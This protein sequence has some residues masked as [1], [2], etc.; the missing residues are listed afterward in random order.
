M[1][2]TGTKVMGWVAVAV[3]AM[4][5]GAALAGKPVMK[6]EL[7]GVVNLNTASAA[8]LDLLPG[9]G[10]KAARRI[11][12]HRSKTPFAKVDDLRK[13]KGFGAK[14]MEKLKSFLTTSGP[15]TVA[16]KKVKAESKAEPAAAPAPAAQG[17]RPQ[18]R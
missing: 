10:E 12:E 14:K 15:T 18:N 5:A 16:V 4:S 7:S 1:K 8:Q 11:I 13:V 9:I 6:K 2:H 3:L 17:R